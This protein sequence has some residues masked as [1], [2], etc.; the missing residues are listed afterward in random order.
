[1][2]HECNRWGKSY[3]I[4]TS[5][6]TL[7]ASICYR[8]LKSGTCHLHRRFEQCRHL[9]VLYPLQVKQEENSSIAMQLCDSN[10]ETPHIVNI[11]N[12]PFTM[13][14]VKTINR[15]TVSHE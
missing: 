1:L 4:A 7:E 12:S 3:F 2:A 13:L 6:A 8:A 9:T 14:R 11:V 10:I 5:Q 15:E